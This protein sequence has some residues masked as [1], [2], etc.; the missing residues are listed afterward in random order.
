MPYITQDRRKMFAEHVS[1]IP[2]LLGSGLEGKAFDESLVAGDLN[3][4]IYS[5]AKRYLDKKGHRYRNL[6]ML[7]GALECCK[8]EIYRRLGSELEDGAIEKNGDIE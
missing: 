3:Y 7:V 5:I 2:D 1:A 8:Q 4:I 6:N